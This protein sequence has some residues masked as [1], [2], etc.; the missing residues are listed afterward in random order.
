MWVLSRILREPIA[1]LLRSEFWIMTENH[2]ICDIEMLFAY[3][4]ED[5][6]LPIVRMSLDEIPLGVSGHYTLILVKFTVGF[7][8][9]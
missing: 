8:V 2:Q 9:G 7:V 1:I 3:G 4:G 5:R 6:Y